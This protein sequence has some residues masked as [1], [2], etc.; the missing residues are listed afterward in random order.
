VLGALSRRECARSAQ[1]S[2]RRVAEFDYPHHRS[3]CSWELGLAYFPGAVEAVAAADLVVVPMSILEDNPG[4]A[5]VWAVPDRPEGKTGSF[6][7]V[8]AGNRK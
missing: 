4:I 5:A 6:V 3:R 7:F 2:C 8:D 1:P